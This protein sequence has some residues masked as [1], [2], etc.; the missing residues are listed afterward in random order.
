MFLCT[1]IQ[2][3]RR[4]DFDRFAWMPSRI[5][6]HR[7]DLITLEQ[8]GNRTRFIKVKVHDEM[9]FTESSAKYVIC[10]KNFFRSKFKNKDIIDVLMNH[11]SSLSPFLPNVLEFLTTVDR[12]QTK[13]ILNWT[14]GLASNENCLAY[15]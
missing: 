15:T 2:S 14:S 7:R 11:T 1:C 8:L 9:V 10:Y 4:K 13:L 3:R 6:S 12:E 5:A